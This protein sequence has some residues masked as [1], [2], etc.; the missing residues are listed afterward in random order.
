MCRN[1]A[2]CENDSTLKL[3]ADGFEKSVHVSAAIT[4]SERA[5]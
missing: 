4:G 1:A 3:A 2:K 5:D